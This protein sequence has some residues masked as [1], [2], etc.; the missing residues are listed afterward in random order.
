MRFM[1]TTTDNILS[2]CITV[3]FMIRFS[4]YCSDFSGIR[5]EL[6]GSCFEDFSF[7]Q[8]LLRTTLPMLGPLV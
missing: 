5:P 7:Q 6:M 8:G 2:Q 1:L 3:S 4:A